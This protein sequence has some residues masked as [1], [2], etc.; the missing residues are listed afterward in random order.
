MKNLQND[1]SVNHPKIMSFGRNHVKVQNI[2]SLLH[3]SVTQHFPNGL[4]FQH[5]H[6]DMLYY[7][8]FEIKSTR[9]ESFYTVFAGMLTPPWSH[10]VVC[11]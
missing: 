5:R 3:Q 1:E 7:I 10:V 4:S 2:H 11:L 9:I 8:L 6:V